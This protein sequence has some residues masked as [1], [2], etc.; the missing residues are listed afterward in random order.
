LS[1]RGCLRQDVRAVGIWQL[2]HLFDAHRAVR[3]D[4]AGRR[5][6]GNVLQP[7]GETKRCRSARMVRRATLR[8]RRAVDVLLD[9]LDVS[10]NSLCSAMKAG[11]FTFQWA[12]LRRLEVD[13]V[14]GRFRNR[15]LHGGWPPAESFLVSKAAPIGAGV[16]LSCEAAGRPGAGSGG[17]SHVCLHRAVR[18]PRPQLAASWIVAPCLSRPSGAGRRAPERIRRRSVTVPRGRGVHRRRRGTNRSSDG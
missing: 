9:I 13:A 6:R 8:A 15:P 2:V 17:T 16:R 10:S 5:Q 11:P 12:C 3:P 7:A 18:A 14:S 4:M 1:T